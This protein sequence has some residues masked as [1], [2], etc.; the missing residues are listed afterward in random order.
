MKTQFTIIE[1]GRRTE[2]GAS[3]ATL[4]EAKDAVKF[5]NLDAMATVYESSLG[6]NDLNWVDVD[7]FYSYNKMIKYRTVA[8]FGRGIPDNSLSI[9][10]EVLQ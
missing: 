7:T 5:Y 2:R 10:E 3:F 4:D 9:R 6:Q 8:R 1:H